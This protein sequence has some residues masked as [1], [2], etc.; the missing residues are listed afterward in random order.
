[1][2]QNHSLRKGLPTVMCEC[3]EEI[4]VIPDLDEMARC[5]ETHAIF[6][7]KKEADPKKAQNEHCRIEEQL[8]RKVIIKIAD[9]P[10]QGI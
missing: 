1:M 8:A 9:M 4:L 2:K 7:E 6:H 3:G 5:I 10:N